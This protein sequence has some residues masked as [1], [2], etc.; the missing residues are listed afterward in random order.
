[1]GAVAYRLDLPAT[2][3]I[4]PVFHV[5]QLKQAIG[6]GCSVSPALPAALESWQVPEKILQ[7]RIVSQEA[8]I[9]VKWSSLP[10]E[11][12]TWENLES[13]RHRFPAAPAW[14]HSGS[15]GVGDVSTAGNGPATGPRRGSRKK[16][17]SVRVSGHEYK[18]YLERVAR[19]R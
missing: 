3:S 6:V 17:S 16:Q 15:Q 9:L 19:Y 14:G 12:A 2:T 5:S 7:R 1:V 8:Q 10:E 13:L 4:H 11:L 18:Y